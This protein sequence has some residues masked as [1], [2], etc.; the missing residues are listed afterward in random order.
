MQRYYTAISIVVS[1]VVTV[2]NVW[3]MIQGGY[4]DIGTI[5]LVI[6]YFSLLCL[7]TGLLIA[8]KKDSTVKKKER[9]EERCTISSS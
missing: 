6:V 5:L 8:K 2:F 3:M 4:M 1:T 7:Y 9:K